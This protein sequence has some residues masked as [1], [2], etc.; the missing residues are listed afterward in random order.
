[1]VNHDCCFDCHQLFVYIPFILKLKALRSELKKGV[2]LLSSYI[3]FIIKCYRTLKRA[4]ED[5]NGGRNGNL[6]PVKSKLKK[7]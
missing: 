3:D 4:I 1:M 6:T 5:K 7:Y 2:T